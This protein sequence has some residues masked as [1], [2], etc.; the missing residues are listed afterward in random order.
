[1]RRLLVILL[2]V[3]CFSGCSASNDAGGD[4]RKAFQNS[5]GSA[6]NAVVYADYGEKVYDFSVDCSV[7]GNGKLIFQLVEPSSIADITGYVDELGSNITFDER[8]LTFPSL[9]DDLISPVASPWLLIRAICNGYI[10]AEYSDQN[11]SKILFE[12]SYYQHAFQIEL[13]CNQ[14]NIPIYA[15]I[16]WEGRRIIALEIRNFRFM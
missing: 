13:T 15:D 8:V 6:F 5:N 11:N 1:M 14:D 4:L 2:A 12:D 16:I 3:L 9:A 7:N 10:R